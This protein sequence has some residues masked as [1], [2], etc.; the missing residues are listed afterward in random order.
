MMGEEPIVILL[1]KLHNHI[2]RI[3]RRIGNAKKTFG[4][5]VIV[6]GIFAEKARFQDGECLNW[7]ISPF[8]DRSKLQDVGGRM[9]PR[10]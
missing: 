7:A 10:S 5:N 6:D 9:N 2:G 4:G 3:D 1:G 8:F